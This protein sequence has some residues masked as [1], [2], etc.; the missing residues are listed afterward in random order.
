VFRWISTLQQNFHF[1]NYNLPS[2]LTPNKTYPSAFPGTEVTHSAGWPTHIHIKEGAN[3][4]AET[5]VSERHSHWSAN[6][7]FFA[8]LGLVVHWT[9]IGITD[10]LVWLGLR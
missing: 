7:E 8:S 3:L 5:C 2:V 10:H 1:A 6:H 4:G 9:I